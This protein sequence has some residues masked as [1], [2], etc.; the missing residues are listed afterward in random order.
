MQIRTALLVGG[1]SLYNPLTVPPNPGFDMLHRLLLSLYGVVFAALLSIVFTAQVLGFLNLY[2]P[3]LT[4]GATLVCFIAF[5]WAYFRNGRGW[6]R[7][8]E[9]TSPADTRTQWLLAGCMLVL[10]LLI[11]VLRMTLWPYSALGEYLPFD[12][13][14]YHLPKAIELY[15]TGS[16]W[17][18]EIPYGQYPVGYESFA[19]FSILLSGSYHGL[20]IIHALITLFLILTIYLMLRRYTTLP[21]GWL[22]VFAVGSCFIPL[23]YSQVV[24]V[25]KNDVLLAATVLAAVLHAPL[26]KDAYDRAWHPYGLAFATMLSLSVKANGLVILIGLWLLVFWRWWQAYHMGQARHFL[27]VRRLI[28][29]IL[30][31]FPGGLWVIR[32]LFVMGRPYSPEVSGFF[33]TSWLAN[34]FNPFLYSD[35]TQSVQVIILTV[36]VLTTVLVPLLLRWLNPWFIGVLALNWLSIM[37]TPLG[38][39]RTTELAA[40]HVEW[41]YTLYVWW[42]LY[43]LLIVLFAPL[44][45]RIITWAE[46]WPISRYAVQA[47]AI[48][49]TVLLLLVLDV[50][51]FFQRDEAHLAPFQAPANVAPGIDG[52]RNV[53][54]YVQQ[55]IHDAVL[56]YD[57]Y[58][59]FYGYDAAFSN[60][61]IN[62][63]YPLGMAG[64]LTLPQPDCIYY[65][66]Y[67]LRSSYTPPLE[68]ADVWRL[69]Y[70]DGVGR[71]YCTVTYAEQNSLPTNIEG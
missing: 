26:S 49:G 14:S 62:N 69:L 64:L 57:D 53:Y 24:V 70:D 63:L 10:V 31:M 3:V 58:T 25:G 22:L 6:Y 35:G 42:L 19:A 48:A 56:Y 67:S 2:T 9:E 33:T 40:V 43:V 37:M 52:Y 44:L 5:S 20:G 23:F 4:I 13:T 46:T 66:D 8:L 7:R 65:Y 51:S 55:H 36:I 1:V 41:R 18:F 30:I 16:M 45:E 28:I 38:V 59:A 21:S 47:G 68:P 39:F 15:R 71:V 50:G 61:P 17:T 60:H 34:I 27:S 29:L 54:D 32:N 12:L 11:F